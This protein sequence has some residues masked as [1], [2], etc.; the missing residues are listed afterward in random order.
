MIQ[1]EKE[2][3]RISGFVPF[4]GKKLQNRLKKFGKRLRKVL[5]IHGKRL[6]Y[7]INIKTLKRKGI[8]GNQSECPLYMQLFELI[9]KNPE[10]THKVLV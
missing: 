4:F 1:Y 5:Y 9:R 2:H 7:Y 3:S 6:Q 8:T 10:L